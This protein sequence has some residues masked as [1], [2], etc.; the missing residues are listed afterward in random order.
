M[1][2]KLA[3]ALVAFALIATGAP[4]S[5]DSSVGAHAGGFTAVMD[6]GKHGTCNNDGT[7]MLGGGGMG[8]LPFPVKNL[9]YRI[10][11]GDVLDIPNGVGTLDLCGRLTAPMQDTPFDV[12]ALGV[13]ASCSAHKGWGGQ[14][15]MRFPKGDKWLSNV[16]WKFSAGN[17]FTITADVGGEKGKKADLFTGLVTKFS[18]AIFLGC[19]A[20]TFGNKEDP[21]PFTIVAGYAIVPG[22]GGTIPKKAPKKP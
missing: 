5:A 16:G 7:G 17:L 20:K 14:G 19:L 1:T 13:G 11:A 4:A 3:A 8:T 9:W 21:D 22:A 12:K 15:R 18:E 10:S 6:V 2:A